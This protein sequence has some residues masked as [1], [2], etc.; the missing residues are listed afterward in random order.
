MYDVF[1]MGCPP[2]P[3]VDIILCIGDTHTHTHTHAGLVGNMVLWFAVV[4]VRVLGSRYRTVPSV[5]GWSSRSSPPVPTAVERATSSA[6][7]IAVKSAR[8][9]VSWKWMKN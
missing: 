2:L 6:R 4:N 1:C 7:R 9:N 3:A 5:P 8:E